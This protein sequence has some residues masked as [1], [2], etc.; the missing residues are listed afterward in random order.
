MSPLTAPRLLLQNSRCWHLQRLS[1]LLK[2]RHCRIA[3]SPLYAAEVGAM[4]AGFEGEVLLGE[5]P[6]LASLANIHAHPAPHFHAASGASLSLFGLQPMSH[7]VLDSSS[8]SGRNKPRERRSASSD[9]SGTDL[10]IGSLSQLVP[11]REGDRASVHGELLRS[12]WRTGRRDFEV[13]RSEVDRSGY[14]LVIECAGVLRRSRF[15]PLATIDEASTA[16]FE[17]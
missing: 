11:P 17:A 8:S 2:D 9:P 5:A 7:I 16:L 4:Q 15:K 1:D 10:S 12:L 14:D 13:L 6:L 3:H